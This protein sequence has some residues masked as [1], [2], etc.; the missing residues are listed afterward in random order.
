MNKLKK[1]ALCSG[2]VLSLLL[3][4]SASTFLYK[5][6]FN[7]DL[8][9]IPLSTNQENTVTYSDGNISFSQVNG[10][11]FNVSANLVNDE[12]SATVDL[13]NIDLGLFIPTLPEAV[14]SDENLKKWF[15]SERE[16]NRQ[17]VVFAA[18]SPHIEVKTGKGLDQNNVSIQLTNNCLGAGYWELAVY[19]EQNGQEEPLYKG[20]F[21]FP[22]G[23]YRQLVETANNTSYW[24]HA[25]SME[26][27]LGFNFNKGLPFNLNATRTVQSEYQVTAKYPQDEAILTA[28]EQEKKAKLVVYGDTD[29]PLK[30]WGDIKK[31]NVQFQSFLAPG[32]YAKSSLWSTN[33]REI[34]NFSGAVVRD[35][36]SKL[37]S[38][39]SL[40]EIE[41]S[42]ENDQG[43]TRHLI[44]S[45]LDMQDL[46]QLEVNDY[47]NGLYMP[48]GFGTTFT[49]DYEDLQ[50][51]PPTESAFFSVMLDENDQVVDYRHDIGINGIVLHRD[52]TNPDLVHIYP[53]SYERIMLV[54]HY[55]ID[56]S[57]KQTVT[58]HKKI[59]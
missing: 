7:Y 11:T 37:S 23:S 51:N 57:S 48:I 59:D 50:E 25:R 40:Q 20:F 14:R 38:D 41:L 30:T 9:K 5:R 36:S 2:G 43:E 31:S 19:T 28:G 56:M 21:T 47:S 44:I 46:P 12:S 32:S 10:M 15:L 18:G 22:R 55:I 1:T 34:T 6:Y 4:I 13:K 3:A 35:I 24:K 49:Q 39:R 53:L 27:W 54:G 42:F 26:G 58:A 52:A 16:F 45:G 8:T 33:Y 17:R 29:Q